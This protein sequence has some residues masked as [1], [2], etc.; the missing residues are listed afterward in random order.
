[1][2]TNIEPEFE[3]LVFVF[4]V[5]TLYPRGIVTDRI[6]CINKA[7][8]VLSE[9]YFLQA[10]FCNCLSSNKNIFLTTL[11]NLFRSL[12]SGNSNIRKCQPGICY[13]FPSLDDFYVYKSNLTKDGWS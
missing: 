9:A 3:V 7:L 5:R 1:M 2:K 8:I 6:S 11:D 4:G 12:S 10:K 13:I